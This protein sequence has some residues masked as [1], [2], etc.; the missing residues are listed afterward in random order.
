MMGNFF[1][2]L[3]AGAV[4]L[5]IMVLLHEWGHF[6]AA[7]ACGVR[8][9][10]FSIGFGPRI[11]GVKRGD[12]DYRLSAL[13]LGGYVK[14][15]G[16]NPAEERSGAPN[17]FLSRPRW[18][19]FIIAV[20]GPAANIALTFVLYWGIYAVVGT[21]TDKSVYE[22][23][24]VAAVPQTMAASGVKPADRILEVNGVQT[25]DW[26]KVFEQISKVNP[27]EA[28]S[29][30][31]QRNGAPAKIL[32]QAPNE[33]IT[34][35][36]LVGYLAWPPAVDYIEP[37]FPADKA[38]L[39]PGDLV[40]SVNGKAIVTWPQLRDLIRTSD[41]QTLHFVVRRDGKNVPIDIAPRHTMDPNGQMA[42][43]I[44]ADAKMDTVFERESI[45]A[46]F[47]DAGSQ[48]AGL[49]RTIGNVVAGLFRG[50]VSVRDL[51]GPVGIVQLSGQAAKRGALTFLPFM[52][53]ISLDLGLLNLLPIP[54]L[55]GGHVLLLLIEGTLR[56][57]LSVAAKERFVQ[58]GL[59]F[60][61][62]VFAFVMYSDIL[63]LLQS[64]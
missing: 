28:V 42:W 18:Q 60:L 63:R 24:V 6:V 33:Q 64:H 39:K 53:Y 36:S 26:K 29:L 55:D 38:G 56:R 34:A 41:G 5:G 35:D 16:D 44:G 2:D 12:T 43:V 9:D 47:K 19:R 22:P 7:K 46:S 11:W 10:V 50:R 4:V 15:A 48:T 45:L 21:P 30:T 27:G 58:V 40:A 54:I 17:E 59:V 31:V 25:S 61:L 1:F 37:G 32:V 51:A 3:I 52:A 62:G 14:M 8:V 13:P 57:D 23:P 20:A 49:T